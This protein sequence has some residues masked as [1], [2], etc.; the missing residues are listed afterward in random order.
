MAYAVTNPPSQVTHAL[1]S[2]KNIWIYVSA[3]AKATVVA[4]GYI[5]NAVQLGMKVGDLVYVYDTATPGGA[6]MCVTTFTTNAANLSYVAN[7]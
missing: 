2:G 1:G 3:D 6:L 7:S 4:A 5:T